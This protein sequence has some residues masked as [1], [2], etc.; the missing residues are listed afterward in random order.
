MSYGVSKRIPQKKYA[1][2]HVIWEPLHV[3]SIFLPIYLIIQVFY[4]IIINVILFLEILL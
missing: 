1:K 4:P 3:D 2:E